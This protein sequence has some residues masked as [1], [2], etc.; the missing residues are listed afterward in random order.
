MLKPEQRERFAAIL[1]EDPD[2]RRMVQEYHRFGTWRTRVRT[3][4]KPPSIVY[5]EDIARRYSWIYDTRGTETLVVSIGG[6][7]GRENPRVINLNMDAFDSVDLVGDGTNLPL[8]EE[9]VDT[10]TC[11]AVIEHV[12]N[13][14]DL[15]SEMVRVLKPGGFAQLMVPFVFPFHAYPGDY[16][17]Y[18]PSGIL[19]MTRGFE[20]VEL[21]V[22]TGPTSAML[23]MFR[24]YLRLLLPGGNGRI[25]RLFLNGV[26]GWLTF[27][28]KYLDRWLNRKPEAAHLAAA[29]YYLGRKPL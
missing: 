13:P 28:F 26:S 7:P 29:F 27:P 16:Q 1:R 15:L 2:G 12:P 24:E 19:E 25:M 23:V 17:R 21:S 6:G 14:V 11:N 8:M 10:V 5:D 9:S 18:S 3:L 4:L 20:K 22:L